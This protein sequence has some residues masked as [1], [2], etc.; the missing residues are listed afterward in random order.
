MDF[1]ARMEVRESSACAGAAKARTAPVI[2][3]ATVE[4]A[5][6]FM[7][8]PVNEKNGTRH[9]LRKMCATCRAWYGPCEQIGDNMKNLFLT[10]INMKLGFHI[11]AQAA[12]FWGNGHQNA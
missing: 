7:G 2:R 3:P 12:S 5:L 4:S 9:L 1:L 10:Y 6:N 8:I 11:G